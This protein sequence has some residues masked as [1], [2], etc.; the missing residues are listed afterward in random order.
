M[1]HFALAYE[2]LPQST[3]IYLFTYSF[4]YLFIYL[5]IYL[6]TCLLIYLFTYLLIH[7]FTYLLIYLFIYLFTYLFIYVLLPTFHQFWR[8]LLVRTTAAQEPRLSKRNA[9]VGRNILTSV[10]SV[11][12]LWSIFKILCMSFRLLKFIENNLWFALFLFGLWLDSALSLFQAWPYPLTF[13]ICSWARLVDNSIPLIDFQLMNT[14]G[15]NLKCLV[16]CPLIR[17]TFAS[18]N[19]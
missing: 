15:T 17:K 2:T 9:P 18:S 5:L 3:V 11:Y 1:F 16:Q 6:F 7:L 14:V 4:I 8:R 12:W 13:L 19:K 10:N